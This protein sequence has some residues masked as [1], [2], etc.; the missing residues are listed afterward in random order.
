MKRKYKNIYWIGLY[1]EDET[2]VALCESVKDF[3]NYCNITLHQASDRLAKAL[4]GKC[5]TIFV[6]KQKL[7]IE[8]INMEEEVDD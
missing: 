5:K 3:A 1:N 4:H 6:N 2:C 8:F 7:K